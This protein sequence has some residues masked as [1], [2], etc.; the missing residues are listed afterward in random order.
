MLTRT[1]LKA[2]TADA[3]WPG[4]SILALTLLM[5]AWASGSLQVLGMLATLIW[6]AVLAAFD[7]QF[8]RVPSRTLVLG[9][10]LF[11]CGY[12]IWRGD[13]AL[14]LLAL[15]ALGA[16][17]RARL[18]QALQRPAFGLALA[19]VLWL[20]FQVRP[21]ALPGGLAVIG[22]WLMFEANWWA[23]MDALAAMALALAW[24]DL[25]MLAAI[26]LSHLAIAI[27]YR[28]RP[29]L[30]RVLSADEL[31][32]TGRPGFPALALGMGLYILIWLL[33]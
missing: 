18:K 19:L 12:A 27:Y 31:V 15:V 23:G 16:S 9:P 2:M 1:R 17:E 13:W 30:P 20:I 5:T 32:K 28:K 14:G 11:A 25:G 33:A 24:P 4:L 26:G 7:V 3:A 6:L 8:L 10:F 22:F 21:E 29:G